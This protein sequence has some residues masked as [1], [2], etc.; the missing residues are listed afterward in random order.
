VFFFILA[1]LGSSKCI[2]GTTYKWNDV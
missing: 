2:H 1:C